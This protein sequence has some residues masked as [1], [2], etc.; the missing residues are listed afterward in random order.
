[1]PDLT[2]DWEAFKRLSDEEVEARARAD[3][4]A[5]PTAAAFW[6]NAVVSMPA[7]KQILSIRI[8]PDI[9]RW[10]KKGGRGYQTRINAVLKSYVEAQKRKR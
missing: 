4:D 2:D 9:L 1:L 10:F 5:Q 7:P 6:K 3:P 8:D